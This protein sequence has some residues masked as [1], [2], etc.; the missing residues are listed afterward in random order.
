MKNISIHSI[1]VILTFN[2]FTLS[3]QNFY[4]PGY[5]V[6][7]NNDTL[8]GRIYDGGLLMNTKTCYFKSDAFDAIQSF[9]ADDIKAYMIGDNKRY[10]SAKNEKGKWVF[11]EVLLQG[12]LNLHY[13]WNAKDIEFYMHKKDQR[14]V[15]LIN[16]LVPKPIPFDHP[17]ATAPI[18]HSSGEN[19]R[20]FELRLYRDSLY[21]LLDS[22]KAILPELYDLEYHKKYLMQIS[23]NYL[24]ETCMDA[25]CISYEKDLRKI[26]DRFGLFTGIT[27]KEYTIIIP[28]E[29]DIH[30]NIILPQIDIFTPVT[31]LPIGLFCSIPLSVFSDRLFFQP[32]FI[33]ARTNYSSTVLTDR[34]LQNLSLNKQ[35]LK[36][37]LLLKYQLSFF[38]FK[39]SIAAGW[40]LGYILNFEVPITDGLQ[41]E[42]FLEPVRRIA[43]AEIAYPISTKMDVFVRAKIY[44]KQKELEEPK[45]LE[46][47]PRTDFYY[48]KAKIKAS[49]H[50]GITF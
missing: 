23:K 2:L 28:A 42:R 24:S 45:L 25:N 19:Y 10:E 34:G 6:K 29:V 48:D 14:R 7:H 37:P 35:A 11:M 13:L 46:R 9:K 44:G 1:L 30:G 27:E 36:L 3:A 15:P 20:N 12:E 4:K 39:P 47:A 33:Y 49:F 8:Y 31:T 21:Q 43:Q 18:Y 5:V 50:V 17:T 38:K 40:E 22:C 41:K 16:M 32:E 26:R